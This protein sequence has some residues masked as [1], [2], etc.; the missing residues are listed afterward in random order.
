MITANA[1]MRLCV[2]NQNCMLNVLFANN[3]FSV[4]DT[5]KCCIERV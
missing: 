4:Q 1:I 3:F 5:L 2:E